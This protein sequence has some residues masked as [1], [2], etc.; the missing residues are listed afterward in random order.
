MNYVLAAD[1]G[2]T[3]M[4][5]AIID[6][7]GNILSS[8]RVELNLAKKNITQEELISELITPL[9]NRLCTYPE[10]TAIGIGFPGFFE[11]D[12]GL[13]ITS[14]NLP[15]LSHVNISEQLSQPLKCP[16]YVQN[17]ALCATLGEHQFGAGKNA[18]HLLHVTLGTGVGAG[19]ILCNQPYF[20]AN[21]MS[22]E[23][24][25]LRIDYHNDA[26]LCG[27]GNIGCL[28]AYASAS[29]VTAQY[30]GKNN[31]Q[32]NADEIFRRAN[33]GDKTALHI[34]QNA[35]SALGKGL[36]EA[37]NLLDI[38]QITIGGGLTGAW[39]ILHPALMEQLNLQLIS[40]HKNKVS[41]CCSTL[42]DCAGLLGAA[43]LALSASR[44][45]RR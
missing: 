40:P 29:A 31:M 21:G 25:H 5:L 19:L 30:N 18:S 38:H 32:L 33:N 20:G 28:E 7:A 41:V 12:S 3:N 8:E 39:P 34:L 1:V 16:V 42:D 14:P 24:G 13:L 44:L 43:S 10:T 4:R 27:C 45:H 17:D 15:Q 6:S 2:G 35:G 37:I 22:M 36:A 26:R 11:G 23:L 9:K